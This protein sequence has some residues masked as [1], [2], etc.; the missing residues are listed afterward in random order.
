L[1]GNADRVLALLRHGRVIDHQHGI[2]AADELVSLNEKLC[3][4]RS[5]VP[6]ASSDEMVQ[7]VIVTRRKPL[8]HGRNALAI[9]RPDQP[10][11]VER[12]HPPPRLVTQP[13]QK[14]LEPAPKLPFP[15]RPHLHGRPL[16]KPTNHE[17]LKN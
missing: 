11:D 4:Q 15:I 7:P 9:T 3:L 6:H 10:R 14:R 17:S 8:G 13:L 1:R 12:T 2:A 5:R 16:H